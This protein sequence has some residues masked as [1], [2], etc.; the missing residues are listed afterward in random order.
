MS[1]P[2][3]APENASPL[4]RLEHTESELP[5]SID[6]GNQ[7]HALAPKPSQTLPSA[8][9][10][11]GSLQTSSLRGKAP[12]PRLPRSNSSQ[13][14]L[15]QLDERDSIFATH[16]LVNDSE[17]SAATTP[18]LLP[19][20]SRSIQDVQHIRQDVAPDSSLSS[21]TT[22]SAVLS[23]RTR[24]L[25]PITS[26]TSDA[27]LTKAA[28]DSSR[29]LQ[30]D[31]Y[32]KTPIGRKSDAGRSVS[33][34]TTTPVLAHQTPSSKTQDTAP[35]QP[36]TK[37]SHAPV[38]LRMSATWSRTEVHS[39]DGTKETEDSTAVGEAIKQRSQ[40][41]SSR[42]HTEE[43]IEATLANEEP[44]SN[45]RSRKA[46]H[47]LGLFKENAASQESKKSKEK[48]KDGSEGQGP[49]KI[50]EFAPS[51]R[52][53]VE[54]DDFEDDAAIATQNTL[55][56]KYTTTYR[57]GTSDYIQE[58]VSR[59]RPSRN[60]SSTQLRTS[61]LSDV[62]NMSTV[63]TNETALEPA[64]PADSV[65][66][67]SGHGAQGTLPLRLLEDIRNHH[68]APSTPRE[69]TG[70]FPLGIRRASEASKPEARDSVYSKT[71]D[72]SSDDNVPSRYTPEAKSEGAAEEDEYEVENEQIFSATYYPHHGPSPDA[73][74]DT[75]PDQTSPFESSDDA[76]KVSALSSI[77]SIDEYPISSVEAPDSLPEQDVKPSPL[78]TYAGS[79]TPSDRY[80]LG[81]PDSGT[82]SASETDYESWDDTIRSEQGDE[83]GLTDGGDIT[84]TATPPERVPFTRPKP[85]S[86]PLR[87]VELRPYKHQVGGHTNV[88][89]FSKQAICKQLNNR[90]NE[91][92]EVV[93]RR[94]PELLKF[95]PRCVFQIFRLP[96]PAE[97]L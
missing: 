59:Q 73:L 89:S 35:R 75:D 26:P 12:R 63:E 9:T 25:T 8:I 5:A 14:Q 22:E 84:P 85:R 6:P 18:R 81:P 64:D 50:L 70:R 27:N 92:Y 43:Q 61:P 16:Y 15:P 94:H 36:R 68:S 47:Y 3:S 93:E 31:T 45:A 2:P 71:D 95:M 90:E 78:E 19:T 79:R 55:H 66:W 82:S 17:D 42:G 44:L 87:A 23:R 54:N 51:V 11:P 52:V 49:M 60:T 20:S 57:L 32:N 7:D 30:A 24:H 40:R 33:H 72:Q 10:P 97:N 21:Q 74:E 41:S 77:S 37:S 83:S 69:N 67:R 46:S 53:D 86:K 48:S 1:N 96:D 65:E 38:S 39:H 13:D 56:P 91:F 58:N 76:I 4:V 28:A 34:T 80:R 88:Y 29:G 62:S